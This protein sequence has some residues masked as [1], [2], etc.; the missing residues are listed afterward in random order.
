MTGYNT[1]V[2]GTTIT[3]SAHN[4]DVRDQVVSQFASASARD[5][6]ITSPLQGMF[7]YLKDVHTLTVYTGAAWSTVGPVDGALQ[8]WPLAPSVSQGATPSVTTVS[9]YSR[10]GRRVV[11]EAR[12]ACTSGGTAATN[13]IMSLPFTSIGYQANVTVLGTGMIY[14]N[15]TTAVYPGIVTWVNTTT[16]A[17]TPPGGGNTT[18]QFLGQVGSYQAALA[19]GDIVTWSVAYEASTDA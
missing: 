17:L 15:S 16:V 2:A 7:A 3:A 12:C 14:R 1:R 13:V 10:V 18:G 8:A 6:V 9:S 19:S 4:S 5:A 11:C